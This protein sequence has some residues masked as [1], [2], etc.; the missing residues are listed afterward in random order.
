MDTIRLLKEIE[1]KTKEAEEYLPE[2][3]AYL[4]QFEGLKISHRIKNKI[5]ILEKI[6]LWSKSSKYQGVNELELLEKISDIIGIT[7]EI[8]E[9][10]NAFNVA[11]RII[12]HLQSSNQSISYTGCI[13]HISDNGGITGYKGLLLVFNNNR[14]PFE[15]QITDA[16]NLAIREATHDEFVKAKYASVQ[17]QKNA[18]EA[19]DLELS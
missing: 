17:P 8:D 14:I 12:Q 3:L 18:Q 13:N 5:R 6:M 7:V 4:Q 19:N 2:L 15:I 1:K 11:D 9:I 10:S 16:K